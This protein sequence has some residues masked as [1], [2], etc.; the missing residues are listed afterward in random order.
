VIAAWHRR[1]IACISQRP[2]VVQV[3][4]VVGETADQRPDLHGAAPYRARI[5]RRN[6]A[7][8]ARIMMPSDA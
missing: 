1:F 4:G 6:E 5:T 8:M 3:R 7:A 2:H